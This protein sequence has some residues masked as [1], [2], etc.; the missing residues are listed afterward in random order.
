MK[1]FANVEVTNIPVYKY[2]IIFE[3]FRNV[4]LYIAKYRYIAE[5]TL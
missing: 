4:E 3:Y 2:W 5:K 1:D